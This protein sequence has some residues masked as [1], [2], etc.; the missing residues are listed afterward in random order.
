MSYF[1]RPTTLSVL[2]GAALL[3]SPLIARAAEPVAAPAAMQATPPEVAPMETVDQRITD[4]HA[5][6]AITPAQESD[7]KGVAKAMRAHA[8]NMEKLIAS[9][10]NQDPAK[11]TAVEDLRIYEKFAQAHVEGLKVLTASFE[12]LY[13]TMPA[14]QKKVADQVFQ[15]FGHKPAAA[16]G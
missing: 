10:S 13:K 7:W 4:L 6:L 5:S 1:A 3:A 8:A 16:H 12:T 2:M 11:L 15:N 9:K 14:A